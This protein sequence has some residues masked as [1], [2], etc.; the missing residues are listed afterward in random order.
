MQIGPSAWLDLGMVDLDAAAS[1]DDAKQS[2]LLFPGPA[3]DAGAD[4][5]GHRNRLTL[6]CVRSIPAWVAC[7]VFQRGSQ[8]VINHSQDTLATGDGSRVFTCVPGHP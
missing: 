3:P 1:G 5:R 7:G 4:R 8:P 2:N 6:P